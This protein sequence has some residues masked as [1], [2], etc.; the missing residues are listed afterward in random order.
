MIQNRNGGIHDGPELPI[1][2]P[3]VLYR[4]SAGQRTLAAGITRCPDDPGA[5]EP[6]RG[7]G[8]LLSHVPLPPKGRIHVKHRRL[9]RALIVAGLA[10]VITAPLAGAHVTVNPG[11]APKG[12]FAKLAFRV[13]NE[14]D[15]A[16][17]TT[18]E[19]NF[20]EDHPIPNVSVRLKD[21]WTYQTET[22]T[23][24]QPLQGDEGEEVTEVV[25]KVTWTAV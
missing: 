24:D 10:I 4:Y 17:T 6:D 23:L 16:G 21:G 19:V 5:R 22:R 9:T 15:N 7:P 25:S 2:R 8:R 1:S 14:Q 3:G 13:P 18:V 11:D 20:P 12:G